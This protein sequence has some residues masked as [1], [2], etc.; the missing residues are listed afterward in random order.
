[1]AVDTGRMVSSRIKRTYNL[2]E[3]TVRRVRELSAGYG[4][5]DTQDAVVEIAIDRLYSS[6]RDEAEAAQWAAA[7]DDPEFRSEMATLRREFRDGDEWPR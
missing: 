5:A 2:T 1:M 6:K 4:V 3:E 7:A